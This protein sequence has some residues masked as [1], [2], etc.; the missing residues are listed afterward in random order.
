MLKI[1]VLSTLEDTMLAAELVI[2][3]EIE[4]IWATQK[5]DVFSYI[6]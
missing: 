2:S 5:P 4:E 1:H 3:Q 6:L